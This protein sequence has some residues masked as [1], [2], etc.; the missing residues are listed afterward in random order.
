MKACKQKRGYAFGGQVDNRNQFSSPLMSNPL[1]ALTGGQEN[2]QRREAIPLQKID[3][4]IAMGNAMGELSNTERYQLSNPTNAPYKPGGPAPGSSAAASMLRQQTDIQSTLRDKLSQQPLYQQGFADGGKPETAEELLARISGKYGVSNKSTLAP[5]PSP[6]P[7]VQPPQPQ[8]QGGIGGAYNALKNRQQ[9]LDKAINGY[10]NGGKIKGPGTP[11]SDSIDA[12]VK[13]TGEP[14]KVSTDERILSK[15]QDAELSKIAND[16]GFPSLDSWLETM[17]GKPVG[18]TMKGGIAHAATGGKNWWEKGDTVQLSEEGSKA[19]KFTGENRPDNTWPSPLID[20]ALSGEFNGQ[21]G[22][23]IQELLSSDIPA[24]NATGIPAQQTLTDKPLLPQSALHSGHDASYGAG[25]VVAPN[26]IGSFAQDGRTY[27]VQPTGQDGIKRVNSKGQNPLFTNIDPGTAA[28]QIAGM[29][30]GAVQVGD[31]KKDPGWISD[32]YG[33][34]MRPTIAMKNQL[35]QMERDRYGRDMGADIKDPRVI[36]AAALN[37]QRMNQNAASDMAQQ[38]AQQQGI[39]AGLDQQIKQNALAQAAQQKNMLARLNDPSLTTEQRQALYNDILVSKGKDPNEGRLI[40]VEGGEE[41]TADGMQKI[42]R[43]SG[44][45]DDRVGR[46]I[47]M[48]EG[49]QQYTGSTVPSAAADMLKK[50]P[51]LAADFDKKYGAGAAKKI[52]GK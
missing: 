3:Q 31:G 40:K 4:N 5:A 26:G 23:P 50:N 38:Q 21:G 48:I 12:N 37:L 32:A 2:Q 13:Q 25:R 6:A 46:F 33:N 43:P 36:A 42:K 14:I 22:R 8:P 41:L 18:P 11:T 34:D 15:A 47:P 16:L 24:S 52:L 9:Q 1:L 27:D 28:Q 44:V 39:S 20:R 30:S 7:V 10:A 51:S 45:Y 35:A 17:T 29:K 19:N 49:Q